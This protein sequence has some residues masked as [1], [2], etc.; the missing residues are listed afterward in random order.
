MKKP[1]A[2]VDK[3]EALSALT[4]ASEQFELSHRTLGVL[5]AL[6]T[7]LPGRIISPQP[8]EAIVFPSNRTL[9]HRLNGMP[10]STLRRH[11][12]HLVKRGIVSRH[13]SPNRKRYARRVGQGIGIAFGFDLSPLARQNYMLEHAANQARKALQE[14]QSIKAHIAHLR[15]RVLEQ[16]GESSLTEEARIVLRRKPEKAILSQ[17]QNKLEAIE[18]SAPDDQN[19]RHLEYVNNYN[20]DSET[21]EETTDAKKT[22]IQ[23]DRP[24]IAKNT[25]QPDIKLVVSTCNEYKSYYPSP[26]RNWHDLIGI[27]ERLTTMIGIDAPVFKQ[28]ITDM[29]GP[30]AATVVLCILENLGSIANPGG[31]LRRLTQQARAGGFSEAPMLT[32]ISN[33]AILSADNIIYR[34]KTVC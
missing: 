7:F 33:R 13:D 5:K 29:G 12:A 18:M 22:P 17:L 9:S 25:P 26:V 14:L 11:L 4:E 34:N 2:T 31:Y 16:S 30:R 15:Q 1:I 32:A 10:D 3:W 23:M 28:A 24:S 6:M 20:P 27:A 8:G 21:L 19:E